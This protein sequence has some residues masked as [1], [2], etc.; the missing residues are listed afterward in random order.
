MTGQILT[1][2][3]RRDQVPE[4]G[5]TTVTGQLVEETPSYFVLERE[6][7]GLTLGRGI[8]SKTVQTTV[9]KDALRAWD[10]TKP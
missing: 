10:K 4:D 5:S 2:H 3:Y 1:A 8:V 7:K 9:Q 6:K